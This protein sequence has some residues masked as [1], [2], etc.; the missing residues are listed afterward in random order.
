VYIYI[1]VYKCSFPL[2]IVLLVCSEQ[3]VS[4]M[5]I[6]CLYFLGIAL[7]ACALKD[8]Y[9]K[10]CVYVITFKRVYIYIYTLTSVNIVHEMDG[11]Y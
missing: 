8:T 6:N 10:D 9:G 5:Y 3:C 7:C 1:Y 2:C 11:R 4:L